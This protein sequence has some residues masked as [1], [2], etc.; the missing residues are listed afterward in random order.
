M[1]LFTGT[2]GLA[3]TLHYTSCIMIIRFHHSDFGFIGLTMVVI[4]FAA[5]LVISHSQCS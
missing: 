5:V 1:W 3:N 4:A 2:L